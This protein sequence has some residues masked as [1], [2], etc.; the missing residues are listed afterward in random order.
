MKYSTSH[1]GFV[2]IEGILILI[3]LSIVGF[4]G[5][6]I[7]HSRQ[8]ANVSYT[9][10]QKSASDTII[11]KSKSKPATKVASG[12][13]Y[14]SVKEFGVRLQLTENTQSLYY[15]INPENPDYAY[16]SLKTVSDIAPNCAADK[17]SMGVISRQT[18]AQ[19]QEAIDNPSDTNSVGTIRI[20]DYYYGY[21]GSHADCTDGTD[22][23]RAAVTQ[24]QKGA[25]LPDTFKTVQA[26]PA[27]D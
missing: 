20:G 18:P 1:H 22:A 15:F 13:K 12:Q 27:G 5:W 8:E 7:I 2:L 21:E 19:R 25:N 3:V 6:F 9:A 26:I 17:F 11:T 16:L 24:A 10:A 4:T 23:M 14:L